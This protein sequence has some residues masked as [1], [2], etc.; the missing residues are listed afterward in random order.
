MLHPH[1]NEAVCLY[2]LLSFCVRRKF[3]VGRFSGK[4]V[5]Y[6]LTRFADDGSE[7][8]F[9]H[10]PEVQT[11]GFRSLREN[12]KHDAKQITF[13]CFS[14]RSKRLSIHDSYNKTGRL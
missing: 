1:Q 12:Q 5:V 9:A 4:P 3:C 6:V 2:F 14:R 10:F 13:T 8:L 7:D 11:A